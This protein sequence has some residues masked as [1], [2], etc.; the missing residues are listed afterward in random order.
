M[1]ALQADLGRTLAVV[2]AVTALL[3]VPFLAMAPDESASTEPAGDVFTARD[4]IDDT[5]A[6]TVRGIGFVIEDPGGDILRAEPL[7]QLFEAQ[8]RL[9]EDPELGPTLFHLLR[10]RCP[11]ATPPASS[12]SPTSSTT[13]LRATEGIGLS[14]ATDAQVEAA[15]AALIER[16]G[17]QSEVLA[18][19]T[20]T[21]QTPDGDWIVPAI[22][23][24]VLADDTVLG[25][26]ATSVNLGG[27]TEPE[28]YDRLVQETLRSAEDLQVNGIAIDVNLTSQEQGAI[29]GPFIGFTILAVLVMVGVTFRSYW[30]LAVVST[31]VHHADRLAEGHQQPHRPEGRPGP[32]AHRPD[33]HDLVRCGLPP[34]TPSAATGRNV[35]TARR[36]PRPSSPASPSCPGALLLAL[37][38]DSM[39]FLAN[40]TSGIESITQFGIGAAIALASAYLLL[41]VVTPLVVAR[42]EAGR[43]P[44]DGRPSGHDPTGRR[45][46]RRRVDDDGVGVVDGVPACRGS[47]PS[48]RWR[49]SPPS[50]WSP[51]CANAV[52]SAP[53]PAVGDLPVVDGGHGL[54]EPVGRIIG[55][56]AR[57]PRIV[58][59]VALVVT[60]AA[61][62]LAVQVPAEFDVEDFFASDTDFVVGLEPT[63]RPRRRPRRRAGSHLRRGRSRRA[64]EPGSAGRLASTRSGALDTPSLA[65]TEAGEVDMD[66]GVFE[67][68]DATW[69]SPAMADLVASRTGVVLTD[70][71]GDAI[72]DSREQVEALIAV[73][74]ETGVPF[75]AERSILTPDDVG[76]AISIDGT[77]GSTVFELGLVDSR[78]P[79]VR[80]RRPRRPRADSRRHRLGPGRL[81]RSG[82]R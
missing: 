14:D 34:S 43:S 76:T 46:R 5:F 72:P 57:H 23:P 33:R 50:S 22:A 20:Q 53:G 80:D 35:P 11:P 47:A 77:T 44:T 55:A 7:T 31:V 40:A 54:V 32:V 30:V 79:G 68:F 64:G 56:V 67:V 41:G 51:T 4:R 75:D 52:A 2:G 8:Q 28:E 71:D 61:A 69:E 74:T 36:P 66:G 60:A 26:G 6:S 12:A 19:S 1:A 9:R 3:V 24:V 13:K 18:L 10:G 78:A 63:R 25:F 27:E 70:A 17:V 48:S 15:G 29:A 42:I 37:A 49:R 38:S 59:P 73:A 82:H 62:T 39:A 45:G 81:V 16:L 58:V 65:R 21:T